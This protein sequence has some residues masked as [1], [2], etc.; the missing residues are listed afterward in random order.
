MVAGII[1]AILLGLFVGGWVWVWLPS[2]KREFD[3][4]AR[5]PLEDDSLQVGKELMP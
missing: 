4:A 5:L 2:H 1:I 3:A